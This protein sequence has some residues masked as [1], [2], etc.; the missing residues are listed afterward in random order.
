MAVTKVPQT[1]RLAIKVQTGVNAAG[2]PV[3]RQRSFANIKTAAVDS[4]V[5]A[6]AQ[7]IAGLQK[8]PVNGVSRIDEGDLVNQ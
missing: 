5:F 7:G 4:D 3:Y 6:V 8:D 2:N 1:S